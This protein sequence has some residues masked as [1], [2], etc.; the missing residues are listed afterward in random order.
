M[1]AIFTLSAACRETSSAFAPKPLAKMPF[2]V[3]NASSTAVSLRWQ[4]VVETLAEFREE[5]LG[6]EHEVG[7]LLDQ[8]EQL[9]VELERKDR[10]LN[11]AWDEI[12]AARQEL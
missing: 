8:I 7:S 2:V 11:A 3:Q 4:P 5:C 6:F 12:F 9:Q 10:E 1:R